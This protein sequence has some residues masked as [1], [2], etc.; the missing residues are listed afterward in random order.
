MNI[1]KATKYDVLT[2]TT[3]KY[4]R[5]RHHA[6]KI[7]KEAGLLSTCQI[8]GYSLYVE[9]AHKKSIESFDNNTLLIEINDIK[10]L[11]GLCKNHHWEYDHGHRSL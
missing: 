10:N 9:C 6:R 8:C 3:Q 1:N 2:K 4:D 11:A 5:I 7:A